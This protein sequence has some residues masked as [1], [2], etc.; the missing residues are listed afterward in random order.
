MSVGPYIEVLR[1]R[2]GRDGLPGPLGRDGKDGKDGERGE[3]GDPGIQGPPGPPGPP[4]GGVVYTRWGRTTC[5]D[6]QG[7]ELLYEG[8]AGGS[9]HTHKGGGANY[10]CLP[11]EP[12][13]SD[14]QP[15]AYNYAN[16]LHGAEY[17]AEEPAGPFYSMFNH[18]VPCA[19]CYVPVRAAV[20]MLPARLTCPPNWT[21]EYNG[22]LM[23]D[24][25]DFYRTTYECMDKD[26]ESIP[27]S[28]ADTN[29]ALFYFTEATC[30]GL[31]CPPY[32]TQKEVTCA[33]CSK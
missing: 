12:E 20:L 1:G 17:Q 23:A 14:Y 33:V 25:Y 31:P 27:G 28:N 29:G 8:I 2:D 4:S 6:T 15:G 22:Y 7:T 18:N 30:N 16:Y 21:L 5:P 9:D 26:P 24:F 13:Y 10:L 11:E 3:R 32:D 19:V